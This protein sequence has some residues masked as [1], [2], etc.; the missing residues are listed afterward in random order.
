MNKERAKE[1]LLKYKEKHDLFNWCEEY[2]EFVNNNI[3]CLVNEEAEYML[4]KGWEDNE[5]PLSY[6][7]IN[8]DDYESLKE[9]VIYE[10][11]N[12]YKEEQEQKDLREEINLVKSGGTYFDIEEKESFKEFIDN[13]E[14]E[15]LRVLADEV[16][17][18]EPNQK[19]VFQWFIVS[20][21][22]AHAIEEQGGVILNENW[23]GRECCGQSLSMD[24]MFIKIYLD[25]LKYWF[26]EEE[27]K[28]LI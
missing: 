28:E 21:D 2:E 13:L 20:S 11:E 7:D 25:K 3:H 18:I 19:E 6:D 23:F 4:K 24:Y 15:D 14:N 16:F 12:N 5:S 10:I 9:N 26:T 27:L 1:I 22:I 8:L 17:Q